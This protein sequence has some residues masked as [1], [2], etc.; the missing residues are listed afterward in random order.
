MINAQAYIQL[1]AF[2]RQDG[3]ILS[4][5]WIASFSLTMY[6]PRTPWGNLLAFLTPFLVWW[7]LAAF[8]S[9]ALNGVISFRRGLA[10]CIHVFFYASLVFAIAQYLYFMFL[11]HGTFAIMIQ[12]NIKLVAPIYEQNGI[13][14]AELTNMTSMITSMTP[15]QYAFI[16]MMQDIIVGV[17]LSF[18]I[19]ALG[20][21]KTPRTRGN[22][23]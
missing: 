14:A 21:R 20:I 18:P 23:I 11:D 3:A 9:T 17:I 1:K 4:L 7:R 6:S 16:F 13:S 2:A 10:Y 12:E 8:R 19:A 5:L 15:I 22:Q